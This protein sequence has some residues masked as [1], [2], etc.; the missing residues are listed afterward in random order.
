MYKNDVP[1]I[2]QAQKRMLLRDEN[3]D[4]PIYDMQNANGTQILKAF[5]GSANMLGANPPVPNHDSKID[6]AVTFPHGKS[7]TVKRACKDDEDNG[8]NEAM[9]DLFVK[10]GQIFMYFWDEPQLFGED[11]KMKSLI[12]KKSK[13]DDKTDEPANL[14]RIVD[15]FICDEFCQKKRK[16]NDILKEYDGF[17]N[18][19]TK[20]TWFQLNKHSN[21][22]CKPF[23]TEKDHALI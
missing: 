1:C 22:V 12:G 14:L 10:Q 17:S 11:N 19:I 7:F 21:F 16:E 20:Y 6:F 5:G 9:H 4:M 2:I 18:C 13:P 8:L 3:P 15:Y 23:F